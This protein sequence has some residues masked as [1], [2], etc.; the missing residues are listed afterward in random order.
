MW[1]SLFNRSRNNDRSNRDRDPVI[2][3]I[4]RNRSRALIMANI[5][6]TLEWYDFFVYGTVAALVLPY[7]FFPRDIPKELATLIS[8][9]T[10]W[11]GFVARATG[12][13][14]IGYISDRFG[15]KISLVIDLVIMGGATLGIA[16]VPG[17]DSIGY[18]GIVIV[19]ILRFFQGIAIGGEWGAASAFVSELYYDSRYRAFWGS[20]VQLGVPVGLLM[21]TALSAAL[22]NLYGEEVFIRQGWQVLFYIGAV[23]AVMG[24]VMRYYVLES[25]L[26]Q[27]ILRR[28]DITRNPIAESIR[29]YWKRILHLVAAKAAQ[30]ALFYVY[31]TYSL[32]YLTGI[33]YSKAEAA[34]AVTIAALFEALTEPLGGLI[35]D[36]VG[37]K[38]TLL[39]GNISILIY[40]LLFPVIILGSPHDIL[41]AS[42]ALGTYGIIHAISF[43]P[44]T[45]YYSE[46]FPTRVRATAIGT[47]FQVT[48][49][50]AGGLS[51]II[52]TILIGGR[53]IEHWFWLPAVMATYSAISITAIIF[54]PETKGK[55][56]PP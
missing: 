18:L 31:A 22:I 39:L 43:A 6:I 5:G 16:L 45:A 38:V 52:L 42:A 53:Y 40:S 11:L 4:K 28:G 55:E 29:R 32:I 7:Y 30:N 9:I 8:L 2:L 26:F 14:V 44:Q 24:G 20:F 12:A 35:A 33:G 51:P 41:V 23:V 1:K 27:Q 54:L 49:I 3:E 21:G 56:M 10:Y 47:A 15:R 36:I 13:M 50:F 46:L 19:S 48:T 25:P 34:L 37:R 17:Y